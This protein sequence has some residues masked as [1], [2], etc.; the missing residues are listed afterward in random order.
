[1]SLLVLLVTTTVKIVA[2]AGEQERVPPWLLSALRE[3]ACQSGVLALL[4]QRA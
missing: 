2:V 4:A 1:M 3:T